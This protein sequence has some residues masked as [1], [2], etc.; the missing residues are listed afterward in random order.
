MDYFILDRFPVSYDLYGGCVV[1]PSVGSPFT[2]HKN[3]NKMKY[4]YTSRDFFHI[5]PHPSDYVSGI[6][7]ILYARTF[8][9]GYHAVENGHCVPRDAQ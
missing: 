7:L 6:T 3:K 2:I 5:L 8:I 9:R 1:S 4:I